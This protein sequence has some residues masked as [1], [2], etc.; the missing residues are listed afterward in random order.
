MKPRKIPLRICVGCQERKPKKEL[1]RIVRTPEGAV[2]LDLTGK[3]SGRGVY[4]C[5]R[6]E[7]FKK[8]LKAKR[9]EKNL[10]RSISE[11]VILEITN[12]LEQKE[13]SGI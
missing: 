12:L 7:C 11:E 5:P 9:L 10:E 2:I 1:V 6:R 3:K 4:I 8:A 13:D